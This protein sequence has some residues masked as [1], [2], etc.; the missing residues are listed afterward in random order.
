MNASLR[1]GFH[2]TLGRQAQRTVVEQ[3]DGLN[4]ALSAA[5]AARMDQ[6]TGDPEDIL[7]A[8]PED[9]PS[10]AGGTTQDRTRFAE[11]RAEVFALSRSLASAKVRLGK[12]RDMASSCEIIAAGIAEAQH[13]TLA[14]EIARTSG[15]LKR[16][17][18]ENIGIDPVSK[19]SR[20]GRDNE[21]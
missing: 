18:G 14:A 17:L 6:A 10:V 11:S 12:L 3:I 9:W 8:L 20:R 15:I 13:G 21:K 1:D 2:T 7:A 16:A 5:G 4:P 19:R